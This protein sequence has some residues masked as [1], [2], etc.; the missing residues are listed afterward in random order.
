[1]QHRLAAQSDAFSAFPTGTLNEDHHFIGMATAFRP[2]GGLRT[3]RDVSRW[4]DEGRA[5]LHGI[6]QRWM[7][8]DDVVHVEWQRQ[9]WLPMFQFDV[10]TRTP[11][12]AVGLV[13]IEFAGAMSHWDIARWFALPDSTLSG[14]RPFEVLGADPASVIEAARACVR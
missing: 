2:S 1:M 6:L 10:R 14:Q 4:I 7:A 9:V 13:L 12:V 5:H 11:R 3:A 8:H